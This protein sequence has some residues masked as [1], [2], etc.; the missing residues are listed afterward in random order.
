MLVRQQLTNTLRTAYR[1]KH[2]KFLS[3]SNGCV[4]SDD[5]FILQTRLPQNHHVAKITLNRTSA[6]NAINREML[7]Q[8]N[9]I[10]D[11]LHNQNPKEAPLCVIIESASAKVFSAGADLKER[12]TMTQEEAAEFVALLRNSMTR[13]SR[14]PMPV[15]AAIEGAAFGGG[16]E[17]ALA[18]DLRVA[19][20]NARFGLTETS[21]AII[22]GAGGTQRLPR[23]V[24]ISKAKEM[25]FTAKRLSAQDA[26]EFGLVEYCVGEGQAFDEATRIAESIAV[27]GPIAIRA[28]KRAIDCGIDAASI[29]IAME[30]ERSCYAETLP[31][32]DRLEGLKAFRE[33]REPVYKGE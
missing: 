7:S 18:T 29:D 9:T 28:A 11:D 24:G 27:N 15:I 14:L 8:F 10:I 4:S 31:T 30:I 3:S 16:L 21:L 6:A 23:L 32:S 22:P 19:G 1:R 17:L 33:G 2:Y 5:L 13:L 25:I 20:S 26:L 12:A